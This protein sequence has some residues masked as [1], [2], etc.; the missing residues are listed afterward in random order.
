[1]VKKLVRDGHIVKATVSYA[2]NTYVT[3][4]TVYVDENGN[5][6][7]KINHN[8][9]NANYYRHNPQYRFHG[10]WEVG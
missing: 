9:V 3:D 1:M 4:R 7:I 6:L 10:Y 5:F 8:F 2:N